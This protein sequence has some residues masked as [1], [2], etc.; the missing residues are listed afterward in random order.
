MKLINARLNK[1]ISLFKVILFSLIVTGSIDSLIKYAQAQEEDIV[2]AAVLPC[3]PPNFD[4]FPEYA[5]G[6]C[7]PV[8]KAGCDRWKETKV[9]ADALDIAA[10]KLLQCMESKKSPEKNKKKDKK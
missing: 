10:Q 7:A 5:S 9:K 3:S 4:V 2:C 8:Y 1:R 6:P